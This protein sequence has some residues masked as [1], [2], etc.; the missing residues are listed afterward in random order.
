MSRAAAE[1][2]ACSIKLFLPACNRR[3]QISQREPAVG[4]KRPRE[5]S[6]ANGTPECLRHDYA[7][8]VTTVT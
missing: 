3:R 2:A 5:L 8:V 1:P 7:R 4:P 6:L